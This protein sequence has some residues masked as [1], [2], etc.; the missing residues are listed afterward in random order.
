M[1]E[2][3]LI[4]II[5]CG[6]I[7]EAFLT[8]AR[9]FHGV[10]IAACA[11]IVPEAAKKRAQQFDLRALTVDALLK[12]SEIGL[13]INLTVPAAHYEVTRSILSANKHAFSEKPLALSAVDAKALV[14]EAD[15][16]GLALGCAPDT[17]LGGG[18][19]TARRLVDQGAIGRA[20]GGTAH[21]LSHGMEHWHPD[22]TFYFKP[23]GGPV[24][25]MGPYYITTL[26]NL[27]GPVHRVAAL[28]ATGFEE[29]IVTS[30][31]RR[32]QRI[33]VE[34]PTTFNA[35]LE[36]AGGVQVTFGA[37]W[38]VWRHGHANPI[39][40]YGA[41]GTMLVPDPNFFSG[42][43]S[44]SKQAGDYT[45]KDTAREPFGAANWPPDK[46]VRANY[47]MLGVA[48]LVSA[49]AAGREPRCSGRLAAHVVEVMEAILVSA[50]EGR[51]V[52][53]QSTVDR[54]APLM[55]E[56]AER[57]VRRVLAQ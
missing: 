14:A 30:V 1:A 27:V 54:P 43:V 19:Q 55:P 52:T 48:E 13:V 8:L 17:F 46:R 15:Q 10:R 38:D 41:E 49:V 32:G 11:D 28:G 26:V 12:D 9:E 34:T 22:P 35:L 29:R 33:A 3:M 7:S 6:T 42:A 53:I 39:E 36:L 2:D 44:V 56:E 37:S 40:L 21:V 51:F 47:R 31:P 25:D 24:F 23:G 20:I 50:A 57:L 5:G 18:G 4:G 16:R 45:V